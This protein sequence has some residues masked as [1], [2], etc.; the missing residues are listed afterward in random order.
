[1]KLVAANK[2]DISPRSKWMELLDEF[3]ESDLDCVKVEGYTN[4]DANS[5]MASIYNTIKRNHKDKIKVIT[6]DNEVFLV[7]K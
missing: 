4:K 5:C 2:K 3:A 7:K 6:R 1:M